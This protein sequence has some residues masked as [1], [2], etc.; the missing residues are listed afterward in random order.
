LVLARTA[1]LNGFAA[2]AFLNHIPWDANPNHGLAALQ[3]NLLSIKHPSTLTCFLITAF[4]IAVRVADLL[5]IGAKVKK[6]GFHP[7]QRFPAALCR[8]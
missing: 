8:A 2:L 4:P 5:L 6:N 1:N 7:R 3:L